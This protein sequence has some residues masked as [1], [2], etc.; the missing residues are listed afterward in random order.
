MIADTT[1]RER[2]HGAR[3]ASVIDWHCLRTTFVTRALCGGMRIEDLQ[4][5]TGHR[6]VETVWKHYYRPPTAHIRDAME[7]A[8]GNGA[9]SPA[10][11]PAGDGD[12]LGAI[13]AGL[14]ATERK[15]LAALL[16]K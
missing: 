5:I 14:S 4:T 15:R 6:L 8:M 7:K 16:A 1:R 3:A 13:V 12:K 10:A 9:H 2:P 11:L